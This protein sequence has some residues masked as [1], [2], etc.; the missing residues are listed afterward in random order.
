MAEKTAVDLYR[1]CRVEQFPNGVMDELEPAPGL[2]DPDFYPKKLK[3]G[4]IRPPDVEIEMIEGVEWVRAGGGTSL[5]DRPGVFTKPGWLSFEIP[6]GTP[7]PESLVVRKTDYNE[8]FKA[9]HYQI[10]PKARMMTKEAL[11]GALHNFARCAIARAVELSR[12]P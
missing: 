8:W 12:L 1:S 7:I 4:R 2:L 3:E 6:E 10:E 9:T 5:F 11:Q